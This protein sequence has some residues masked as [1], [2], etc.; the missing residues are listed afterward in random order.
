MQ[1]QPVRSAGFELYNGSYV[2]ELD[3]LGE[4]IVQKMEEG[5]QDT[6]DYGSLDLMVDLFMLYRSTG[7]YTEQIKTIHDAMAL[8]YV[9]D[10]EFVGESEFFG[11]PKSERRYSMIQTEITE[12]AN[13]VL[14]P[15]INDW[16]LNLTEKLNNFEPG[17]FLEEQETRDFFG[18]LDLTED[19]ML[20]LANGFARDYARGF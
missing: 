14:L 12:M 11:N 10:V 9:N 13:S 15:M 5:M 18:E 17:K 19:L 4:I 6:Y 3:I 20:K 2:N 7:N 8:F 1:N 16:F